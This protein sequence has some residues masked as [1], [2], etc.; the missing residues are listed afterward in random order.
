M[1]HHAH[2][3][4]HAHR[5][6]LTTPRAIDPV[7]G[8]TVDPSAPKGGS[9]VHGGETFHFCSARCRAKFVAE[10]ARYLARAS[11]PAASSAAP[12]APTGQADLREYTCPMHPEIVQV[13]PG[14]CPICG[15]ALEPREVTADEAENPE[16]RDMSRRLWLSAALTLPTFALAMSDLL[17]GQPVQAVIPPATGNLLQ[18]AL[19]APVVLWGGWPFFE[20]GWASVVSRHLN[21]FTLIALGT[22]A[23]FGFSVVA[24]LAPGI[25]PHGLHRGGAPHVY[26]EAAAVIVTLVLVGQVLELRAR[27][28]TSSAIRA[29]LGLAPKTARRLRPDGGEEDVPLDAVVPGDRLRVRPHERVPVDGVV[30]EGRSAVDESS[31][32]GEPLPAEKVAG[33]PLT[34]GTLNG[35]GALVMEARKVG[36]ETLLARIVQLVSEAQRSRAPVQRLADRVSSVFVPAVVAAAALTAIVWSLFGPEPR[37][38]YA[39]VNAVAVLI[40]ACPCALGLAT[41]M[42][43]MVGT[44]RGAQAGVLFRDAQALE[45]LAKVDTLVLDKTGTLTEGRP[46]LS[47]VETAGRWGE[48]RLLA[49][50]AGLERASEHPLAAAIVAGAGARGV[51]VARAEGFE[52][53][54]GEGVVGAV[55]GHRVA[56]GN[57]ALLARLG[58]DA[59]PLAARAAA[60]RAEGQTVVLVAIDGEAA[61]LLAVADPVKPSAAS[62]LRALREAGLRIVMATGDARATAEAVA[63]RLGIDEVHAG[64]LP[65]EKGALVAR[66]KAEGRRVAMAGDGANDAPALALADVGV[67]MGTGTDVAL[68]T[69]AVTLVKGDLEGIVRA[70]R[71]SAAVLRNVRQNLAFAFGYNALGVPLAA[72]LAFPFTG[73]LVGPMLASAA[74]AFSSV[75]VIGNALRLGRARL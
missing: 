34:G 59:G 11:V 7:C 12:P 73:V 52:S 57:E 32:T 18:L 44:G 51:V 16:L 13:G 2:A 27:H 21:M 50:A 66:L 74:M 56:L 33:A 72:G 55:D 54:T 35:T 64:V 68:H 67:A 24:T 17:P 48:A 15:M 38:A 31:V 71:L 6:P 30:L 20:R 25:L 49:L 60:L 1:K 8:M 58:V 75:S 45:L 26:F 19:S 28:A 39:L 9:A 53:F 14:A 36:R 61:G 47:A 69:A 63:R 40:I 23:A 70:R 29:L 42:S 5:P 65:H 10:P 46:V 62:A 22:A 37:L 3:H 4:A 43:V 41:P